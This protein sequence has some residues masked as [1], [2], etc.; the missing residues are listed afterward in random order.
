MIQLAAFFIV[1]FGLKFLSPV[2]IYLILSLFFTILLVPIFRYIDKKGLPAIIAYAITL[3]GFVVILTQLILL[4]QASFQD[5]LAHLGFYQEQLNLLFHQMQTFL[6]QYGYSLQGVNSADFFTIIKQFF[7]KAGGFLSGFLIVVIGVSFLL[8]ESQD[9][10]KK[11]SLLFGNQ[12]M[13]H[14]FFV[15]VQKYFLIKT[16]T[17]LLTG[18]GVA[19]MLFLFHIPYVFMLGFMAFLFNY[20][21][22]VGSI[23]AGI[24]GT[25][26]ALLTVGVENA[27]WVGL[28]YVVI[29]V[30]I[31][32]IIEPKVMGDGLD[33]SPAVVFFSL[34]FWGWLFGI[35]GTFFAV[36]L[37][38]TIKLALQSSPKTEYLARLLSK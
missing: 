13:V 16:L 29:N 25:T 35:V 20:I 24:F 9:F 12:K 26:L 15:S 4:L 22:V 3:G 18:F 2:L 6:H 11:V 34:I 19:V 14:S 21:P 37:T 17:S 28:L 7:A 38:M 36:P 33:L 31:S 30:V 5:F 27:L 1:I 8:F 32:N 23:I 10:G